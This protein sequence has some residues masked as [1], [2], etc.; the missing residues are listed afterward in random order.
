MRHPEKPIPS[1]ISMPSVLAAPAASLIDLPGHCLTAEVGAG[2]GSIVYRAVPWPGDGPSVAIK[3]L[4][5]DL[6]EKPVFREQF[7]RELRLLRSLAHPGI[8]KVIG[9]GDEPSP[10]FSMPLL[11][12][13]TLESTLDRPMPAL[14]AV[15]IVM[16]VVQAI[17]HAHSRAIHHRDI[18]PSNLLWSNDD[19]PQPILIDFGLATSPS[20]PPNALSGRVSGHSDGYSPPEA[21]DD[22]AASADGA[23][24]DIYM[25]GSLLHRLWYGSPPNEM[26]RR[27]NSTGRDLA[28]IIRRCRAER[29]ADRYPTATHLREDLT[30]WLRGEPTTARRFPLQRPLYLAARHPGRALVAGLLVAGSIAGSV[31]GLDRQWELAKQSR[32]RDAEERA[33]ELAAVLKSGEDALRM[34]DWQTAAAKFHEALNR[35]CADPAR[36]QVGRMRALF[37]QNRTDELRNELEQA[38]RNSALS[39]RFAEI[40]LLRAELL[41]IN[42]PD[43]TRGRQVLKDLVSSPQSRQLS[44]AD[45]EYAQ[46][47]LAESEPLMQVHLERAAALEPAHYR[48]QSALAVFLVMSGRFEQATIRAKFLGELFPLDPVAPTVGAIAAIQTGNRTAVEP[49]LA[50]LEAL[51][52]PERAKVAREH[53]ITLADALASLKQLNMTP[54]PQFREAA[55]KVSRTTLDWSHVF[56]RSTIPVIVP[57]PLV[58]LTVRPGAD[59]KIILDSIAHVDDVPRAINQLDQV[60]AKHPDGTLA[61]YSAGL[62]LNQMVGPMQSIKSKSADAKKAMMK[63]LREMAKFSE[64]AIDLPSRYPAT[65]TRYQAQML[66]AF[67][68]RGLTHPDITDQPS[69]SDLS[70]MHVHLRQTVLEGNTYPELRS[71]T[72]DVLDQILNLGQLRPLYLDWAALAPL[73]PEPWARLAAIEWRVTDASEPPRESRALPAMKRARSLAGE[74]GLPDRLEKMLKPVGR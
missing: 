74:K 53:L 33:R 5:P 50:R 13:G 27:P 24:W 72:F 28:A 15:T 36:A 34:A 14:D 54:G 57:S 11:E 56:G 49:H 48:A 22:R 64:S 20:D 26:S 43:E 39:E 67:A 66:A 58:T 21:F 70:R 16:P 32:E 1:P 60:L 18:K 3:V 35:Q 65:A 59:L 8:V 47:L 7:D 2:G 42:L 51:L 40:E 23:R 4:R 73:D 6:A 25:L 30:R 38:G 44:P 31:Y 68:Y 61:Y 17:E 52:G 10:W 69:P 12:G 71:S 37:G 9:S 62:R 29:P 19:V 46:A 45:L 41:L 55:E 63:D